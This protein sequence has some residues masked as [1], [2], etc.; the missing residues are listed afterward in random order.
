MG[1]RVVVA[2][3]GGVDS[4]VA[5]ALLAEQGH[6]V[7]GLTLRLWYCDDPAGHGSCC[8]E[9]ALRQAAEVAARI[10]AEHRVLE[11][12]EP[13]E[14]EVLRP[15]WDEYARGR[16]PNPCVRCNERIK[17][18][19]LLRV[20]DEQGAGRVATGHHARVEPA[21]DG[22]ALLRGRDAEKDQS[23]FL[24]HLT[25]PQLARTLFP[26]GDHTK[27]EVRALAQARGL[28][29]AD[30]PDSQDACLAAGE[31]GFAEALRR[32]FGAPARPGPVLDADGVE[33]GRH[34]G[35]HRF[36]V[37]Q[38]RGL[39]VALGRPAFVRAVEREGVVRVT[40]DP[41]ALL[42]RRLRV[43]DV[44][45]LGPP[46]DGPAEVQIRYRHRPVPARL[47]PRPD[48]T[49]EVDLDEPLRAVT[50]GQAAVFYNGERVLGGGWID[51]PLDATT[52]DPT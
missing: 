10:G 38:R 21:G 27:A 19:A 50:P 43:D 1:E 11:L 3:S 40:T 52:G 12:Q 17:L 20:A 32:R 41:D 29:S 35:I 33:R 24:F 28:P 8:D 5:A 45:W 14:R 25:R 39:G 16:T 2:M 34:D 37:G 26:V 4:S 7:L 44:R 13:F 6:A 22:P 47:R 42:S 23:Y 30:Q 36:T 49:V 48:G 51:G 18:A 15:A 46:A 9:R 31:E